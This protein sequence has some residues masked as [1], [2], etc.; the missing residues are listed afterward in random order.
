MLTK[1]IILGILSRRRQ[2]GYEIKKQIEQEMRN[3]DLKF[4]SIYHALAQ[5]LKEGLIKEIEIE[6]SAKGKPERRGYEITTKGREVFSK[7]LHDAFTGYDGSFRNIEVA[8]H[9]LN[10]IDLQEVATLLQNHLEQQ[11]LALD[12]YIKLKEIRETR[13]QEKVE[14]QEVRTLTP[15]ETTIKNQAIELMPFIFEQTYQHQTQLRQTE[16]LWLENLIKSIQA[17]VN[18]KA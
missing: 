16:I 4:G 7:L 14:Q 11:K 5:F 15:L 3:I 10:F 8:L 9:F 13:G 12:H 1:L 2:H 6:H 17:I 18:E